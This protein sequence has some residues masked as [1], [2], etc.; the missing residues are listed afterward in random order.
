M[1]IQPSEE[2]IPYSK[3]MTMYEELK[4]ENAWLRAGLDDLK[5]EATR[6]GKMVDAT[7]DIVLILKGKTNLPF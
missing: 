3:L 6:Y 7:L 4:K 5:E 1:S 2:K